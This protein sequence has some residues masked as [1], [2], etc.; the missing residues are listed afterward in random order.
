MNEAQT[1]EDLITPA[2]RAAGWTKENQCQILVE[3]SACEF[4]PGRVGKVR[5]KALRADYILTHRGR[6][7]VVVEAKSDE[8]QAIEGYEQALKYGRNLGMTAAYTTNGKEII[9]VDLV[10]GGTQV[11]KA[12]PSPQE[13]WARAFPTECGWRNA[14]D[15]VPFWVDAVKKPRY[16]QVLAVNRVMD[17][18]AEGKK[19]ILLTLATGTGKTFIAFQI[20]WKLFKAKWNLQSAEGNGKPGERTPRILFLTDRN[21]LANQGLIDFSGFDEHALARV[22]P[23]AIHKRGDKVPTNATVFFT[24]YDTFM[25]GEKGE[26]FYRQY[27]PD[28]FDFIIIDECHRGG[29]KDESTWR[30]VL[31]YFSCAC[32]LG[33]TATPKRDVNADTYKYFGR[34]VYEYS[35]LQGIEDGFL[36]PFRVQ[37]AT[38]TIDEYEY[39]ECDIVEAGEEE[40]DKD[41]TYE[42]KDFYRGRIRIR[43]RDEERVK[44]LLGKINPMDKTII[45]CYNQPHAME[46]M[47]MVNKY[48][49]IDEKTPDYCRRVT[50]NDGEDGE[51]F[52][53]E[54]QNNEKTIPVVLTTSQKL[55]TGV[56]AR[57]VRNIVLMRPVNSM[58]EFKQI[59]GRGTRLFDEKFY[60]T[61][62][63]FVG[64]ADKFD[65]PDWDG[66][67][68]C[69]KCGADP[70]VCKPVKG[71][72]NGGGGS[73]PC[74]IC[75][76][77][78]CTCDKGGKTVVISL[79]KDRKVQVKTN[80]KTLIMY[81]GKMISVE[82]FVKKVFSKVTGLVGSAEELRKAWSEQETRRELLAK[83]AENGFEME[84]LKDLQKMM[85]SEDC[86]LLDVLEYVAFAIP[87]QKRI[88]RADAAKEGL[89][90]WVKS[91]DAL[92]FYTFVLDNYVREGVDVFTRDD[93]LSELIKTKYQTISDARLVLGDMGEVRTGFVRLQKEVYAICG[94]HGVGGHAGCVTLPDMDK[95]DIWQETQFAMAAE[96]HE[97]L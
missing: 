18:V 69:P 12:F 1:R 43:E 19:R 36:T 92:G 85:D 14:F 65:D 23:K 7:L 68:V 82:E 89:C 4:A 13:I 67:P 83:L 35:L 6:R 71:G 45:F 59:V 3:Q 97:D 40:L 44:E 31:E 22:T 93:A 90:K 94:G 84:R 30:Q 80:W 48:Q 20:A 10:T 81:D 33:L 62:Y 53:R 91:E 39:D 29:A 77:L 66:P 75:G 46:I 56:D 41:K 95:N 64:A 63:D 32:Q 38:C 88:E 11:V 87:M 26:E 58:V 86:D 70:C 57:N 55:S 34:P 49:K 78:P 17:A 76:N 73:K 50:A 9:E 28:F 16:Y 24:I 60:F 74:A 2:I 79:G 15:A 61:I 51:R 25:C 47:G 54:F 52:L 96:G 42:E 37:K 5:G 8:H 72:G 21:I 27:A